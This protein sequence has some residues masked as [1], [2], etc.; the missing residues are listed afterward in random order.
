MRHSKQIKENKAKQQPP[1]TPICHGHDCEQMALGSDWVPQ[2][3]GST[4]SSKVIE[5][6]KTESMCKTREKQRITK[7][8]WPSGLALMSETLAAQG[9][10]AD[11]AFSQR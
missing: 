5:L 11:S 4:E 10:N 6:P 8:K 1:G 7:K 3:F 2:G 9:R